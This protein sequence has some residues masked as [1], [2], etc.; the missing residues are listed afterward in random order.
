VVAIPDERWGERPAALVV[1]SAGGSA[2]AQELQ[3]FLTA[4]VASWQ[5]PDVIE[6]VDDLPKT[7]VGKIDKRR[8]RDE[9]IAGLIG[10]D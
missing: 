5:V 10:T 2:T 8:L 3:E 9:V 1:L 6:F 4:K 7:G